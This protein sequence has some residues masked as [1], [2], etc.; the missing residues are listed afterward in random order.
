MKRSFS[1]LIVY[2]AIFFSCSDSQSGINTF[3]KDQE[4]IKSTIIESYIDGLQ[5]DGDSVKISKGFHPQ[6]ALLGKNQDGSIWAL[7]IVDWKKK[8]VQKVIDGALPLQDPNRA[9][10]KFQ[11][12]DVSND[13]AIAKLHYYQSGKHV[14]TDYLSLYKFNSEWKIVSKVFTK[15]SK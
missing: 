8:Q 1:I 9:S 11:L 10:A 13:V 2:T 12:I 15:V 3:S 7:P 5:N 4:L 14:Y 6:F